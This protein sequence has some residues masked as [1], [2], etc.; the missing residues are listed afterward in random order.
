MATV[1]IEDGLDFDNCDEDSAI[2]YEILVSQHY[3]SCIILNL[4]QEEENEEEEEEKKKQ[5]KKQQGFTFKKKTW[6]F[7]RQ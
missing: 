5:K 6:T 3:D 2:D 4:N 1:K 7:C